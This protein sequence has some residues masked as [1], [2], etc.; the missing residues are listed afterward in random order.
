[1]GRITTHVLDTALGRPGAGIPLTLCR[2][3]GGRRELARTTTNAD[4]RCE[5]PLLEGPAL[6]PG[7]YELEFSVADYFRAGGVAL[8][9]PPFVDR[10]TLRFG[11]ADADAHY[12]VPLLVSPWSWSTYRGS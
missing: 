10:V 7:L 4:G 1:M 9:Q 3:D 8:S 6:Q 11:V 2:L 12:H 5:H